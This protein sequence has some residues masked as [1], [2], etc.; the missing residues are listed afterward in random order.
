MNSQLSERVYVKSV[1]TYVG[2]PH[3][4]QS[5]LQDLQIQI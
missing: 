2:F 3:F 5:A 4:A 1:E